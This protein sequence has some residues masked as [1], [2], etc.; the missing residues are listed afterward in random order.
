MKEVRNQALHD[1]FLNY[2]KHALA[3]IS[4]SLDKGGEVP[5]LHEAVW[6]D[7]G[8]ALIRQEG[9]KPLWIIIIHRLDKLLTSSVEYQECAK[10][11]REDSIIAK[12]LNNL[13]GSVHMQATLNSEDILN[14]FIT[15][16]MDIKA[17]PIFQ[18]NLVNER[19]SLIENALYSDEIVTDTLVPLLGLE[20][21]TDKISLS[22]D[23]AI[24]RLTLDEIVSC[25]RFGL[26]R[27]GPSENV[28]FN[29]PRYAVKVPLSDPKM[30]GPMDLIDEAAKSFRRFDEVA[31]RIIEVVHALRLFKP[32]QCFPGGVVR[33][34]TNWLVSGSMAGGGASPF[35][36][37]WFA[38]YKL[39][40]SEVGAFK[41]FWDQLQSPEAKR[42]G[43]LDVAI[44]RF[45]Y[46]AERQLPED[47][48][49]DLMIASEALFLCDLS[50]EQFRGELRFRNALR[51]GFFIGQTTNE[52]R[53]I[54][55]L[56]KKA[57]DA[58]SAIVHG[59]KPDLPAGFGSFGEFV[60]KVQ[61]YVRAALHKAIILAS[62]AHTP[63]Y[64]ID[65]DE[66]VFAK[67][68]ESDKEL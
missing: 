48:I 1:A 59:G 56:M 52:R 49:I 34:S 6:A 36:P 39:D 53:E 20:L 65:W 21:K 51:A 26:I 37:L 44:K 29:P 47:Q 17:E 50:E 66:L 46:A 12:Q 38:E 23:L 7:R 68:F 41:Q 54:F 3:L 40:N 22:G 27:T 32:G 16:I 31:E 5:T 14:R 18:D 24:E 64:L 33:R 19:Y 10:L 61:E 67:S 43:F 2:A 28:I 63:K 35:K 8:N 60:S 57:Y 4:E 30:I 62:K 11:L 58:R 15:E 45:G 25:I 13:V 55:R 9:E 42:R